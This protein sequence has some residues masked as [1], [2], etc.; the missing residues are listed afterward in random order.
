LAGVGDWF[1][2]LGKKGDGK[3]TSAA[4]VA[5]FSENSRHQGAFTLDTEAGS[6]LFFMGSDFPMGP[7]LGNRAFSPAG[8][9][10]AAFRSQ[11]TPRPY[12]KAGDQPFPMCRSRIHSIL[13]RRAGSRRFKQPAAVAGPPARD[14]RCPAAL[15]PLRSCAKERVGPIN[16]LERR[17]LGA[18]QGSQ[19]AAARAVAGAASA[20]AQHVGRSER[21]RRWWESRVSMIV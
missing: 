14:R 16:F 18:A 17:G 19:S 10:V 8:R 20:S 5:G 7:S 11:K 2:F 1:L 12:L 4:S 21:P 15:P 9:L 13:L 6:V 3:S